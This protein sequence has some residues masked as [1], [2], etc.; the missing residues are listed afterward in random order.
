MK[1]VSK[2][3]VSI[4][5]VGNQETKRKKKIKA[6]EKEREDSIMINRT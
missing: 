1:K 6:D 3:F 2:A 4:K 5:K